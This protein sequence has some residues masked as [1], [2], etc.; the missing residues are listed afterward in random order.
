MLLLMTFRNLLRL[1]AIAAC[2]ICASST[3][4]CEVRLPGM[5]GSHMVLQREMP[6]HIWGWATPGE[7]VSVEFKGASR[8]TAADELGKWSLYLPAESAGGPY[9]LTITGKNKI[10]LDDVLIGDVWFA[11][12]QSNMEMPLHG[13]PGA[14]LRNSAEEI[15]NANQPNMRL[16][17]ID[18]KTSEFPLRDIDGSWTPCTPQTAA[19]F[20]AAAYFFGRDLA[21][22]EH[23]PIGLIDSTWGGTVVEAWIS[24]DGLSA[25]ASLMPA[26]ADRAHMMD[27]QADA[28]ALLA[29]ERREDEAAKKAGQPAPSHVWK[30]NPT[31][32]GPANLFNGMIAPATPFAIKG[33]IWYQG[34]SNSRRDFAPMYE[35]LFPTLIS[36][37]RAQW[38]EGNF[39][40]LFVQIANF[41]S[42]PHEGWATVREAQRRTLS[43][44]N[45]AMAVTIDIGDPDNV[46]PADKQTVGARLALAA[47]VLAYGEQVE[48]S[49]P[50]FRQ[51]APDG[52]EMRVWFDHAAGGLSAK[53]G[54]LEGFEI[55]GEDH[56]F[57]KADA[58]VDGNTV[59]AASPQVPAPRYVR[60][61]WEN[62]P[63]V[64]LYN[65]A[66]LPASPF[67][68][69][70]E[71]PAP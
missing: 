37:W 34:E 64:N 17:K 49:G 41:K 19:N 9:Q 56:R 40:F 12:G 68:S 67:T 4:W 23:V 24:L 51:A 16:L 54:A 1:T 69:E 44:T 21:A 3:G 26:F 63:V 2:A 33:V 6:I 47:R 70:T 30:P 38:H 39:P 20:S 5:L 22:Q 58:H 48:F 10:I 61:G 55:A 57:V 14:P 46:H 42:G 7:K 62:A 13:W 11:S 60:Y 65:S 25:N 53:G 27:E 18:Q 71:I 52:P 8:D 31:S 66:G 28:H 45:T 43:V 15:A 50:A 36:D 32:W 35:R 29:K 59:V